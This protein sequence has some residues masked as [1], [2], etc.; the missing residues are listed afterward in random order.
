MALLLR[1][2]ASLAVLMVLFAPLV[3]EIEPENIPTEGE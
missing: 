1:Y 2:S 3:K